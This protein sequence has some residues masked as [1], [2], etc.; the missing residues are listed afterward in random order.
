MTYEDFPTFIRSSVLPRQ[1]EKPNDIRLDGE[2]TGGKRRSFGYFCYKG[3]VWKVDEDT[4]YEPLLLAFSAA[5]IGEDPFVVSDT[6][7]GKGQC[8][9][10][11]E[12]LRKRQRS[13]S[14]HMYIY[15]K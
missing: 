7:S 6:A 1:K 13:R 14:K 2:L 4:R 15:S 9:H 12:E 5:E 11:R 10:L 8:L 3:R